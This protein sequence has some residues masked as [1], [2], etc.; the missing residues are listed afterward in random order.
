MEPF[1]KSDGPHETKI[2]FK[3]I[4]EMWFPVLLAIGVFEW[5]QYIQSE[6][7]GISLP[8][9][10]AWMMSPAIAWKISLLG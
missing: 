5:I 2:Y 7:I 6:G 3:P 8:F 1:A 9:L 4:F 10:I